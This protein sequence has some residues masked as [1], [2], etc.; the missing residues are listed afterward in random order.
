M[1]KK[2]TDVE[3]INRKLTRLYALCTELYYSPEV[4]RWHR[5]TERLHKAEQERT[6][7]YK[8]ANRG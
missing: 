4:Q 3:K 7:L 2:L 8:E 1:T 5:A 6:R